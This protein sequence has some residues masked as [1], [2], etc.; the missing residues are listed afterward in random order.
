MKVFL[1]AMFS[2][3]SSCEAQINFCYYPDYASNVVPPSQIKSEYCSHIGYSFFEV[4][5]DGTCYLL[6]PGWES[7]IINELVASKSPNT[8]VCPVIGGN[9]RSWTFSA[10]AS[11][12]AARSQLVQTCS[13]LMN[14]YGFDNC[15]NVD[16][17]FPD[18]SDRDAFVSLLQD[19][20]NGIAGVELFVAVSAGIWQSDISYNIPAIS[21]VCDY[22]NLMTYDYHG[23]WESVTGMN[24][25]L[26]GPP[27]DQLNIVATVNY[28]LS[29]GAPANKLV[30]GIPFYGRT[31]FL[32][33][34]NTN[35]GAPSSGGDT[36][37][38]SNFCIDPSWVV[39]RDNTY[40][41][42]YAVKGNTWL[43][44][45]DAISIATKTQYVNQNGLAG[46]LIWSLQ[47][48]DTTGACGGGE[49]PLLTAVYNGLH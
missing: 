2:Y 5:S 7:G 30:V 29:K 26:T 10:V 41:V 23:S 16:W 22:I 43:S 42:P 24:A 12:P 38:Y 48:D 28:Y 32:I 11:N 20:K 25:P 21:S 1:I 27:G 35:V 14:Q 33:T 49:W 31:F 44:F 39:T 34:S 17:E 19:I 6:N 18:T 8:K 4:G 15:F 3:M 46:T 45:D 47:Q 9:G 36:L 37:E 40:Q 13:A